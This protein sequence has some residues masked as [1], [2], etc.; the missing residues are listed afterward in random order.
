MGKKFWRK[1]AALLTAFA[2]ICSL[3][4]AV[5][6]DTGEIDLTRKGSVSLAPKAADGSGTAVR[7]MA[8]TLYQVAGIVKDAD[9][10]FVYELTDSYKDSGIGLTD[11]S[12]AG[13]ADSFAAYVEKHSPGKTAE[14]STGEDGTVTFSDLPVGL[15]LL[16]Q[17]DDSCGYSAK[18]FLISLPGK[19]SGSD[20]WVYEVDA[21][22]KAEISANPTPTQAP[23]PSI[24]PVPTS[25]T[26]PTPGEKLAQTGQLNWPVPVL[27]AL[28]LLLF[29]VGWILR[30]QDK[31]EK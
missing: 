20:D 13:L 30:N 21:T 27:A 17:A 15:Y 8:F 28:G 23:S 11:L 25:G 9:G 16:I 22:P 24:T 7:G 2:M 26:V 3:S 5:F 1:A 10:N 29:S 31:K 19:N 14:G 6:A 4:A 12:T 18:P